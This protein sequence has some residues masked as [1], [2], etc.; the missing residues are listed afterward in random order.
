[1]K[2]IIAGG[3]NINDLNLVHHAML[4]ITWPVM[5]VVSGMAK[6]VDTL[7]ENWA[8]KMGIPIKQFPANWDKYGR[9][10]GPIRNEEMGD[11]AEALVAI[12]DGKSR[13]TKHMIDYATKRGLKVF[14][15]KINQ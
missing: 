5:E 10:A 2:T 15:Y 12:W 11:Y 14:V 13:G 8:S 4:Q 1:M 7:G 3:R 9:R 6:G